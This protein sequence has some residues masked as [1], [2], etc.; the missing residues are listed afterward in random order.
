V[1]PGIQAVSHLSDIW[2]VIIIGGS[3]SCSSSQK[4]FEDSTLSA[5]RVLY[6]KSSSVLEYYSEHC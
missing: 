6:I 1:Y 2:H 3:S 4:Y 5:L